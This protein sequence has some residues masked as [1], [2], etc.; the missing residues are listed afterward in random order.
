MIT[1]A[2]FCTG[3]DRSQD[4][5]QITVP[6]TLKAFRGMMSSRSEHE[7][8]DARHHGPMTERLVLRL[9]IEVEPDAGSRIAALDWFHIAGEAPV[10]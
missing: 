1:L 3:L 8:N 2:P 7:V 4:I 9:L 6:S 10:R 5:R